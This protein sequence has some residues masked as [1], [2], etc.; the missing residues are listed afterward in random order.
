MYL[1]LYKVSRVSSWISN[2]RRSIRLSSLNPIRAKNASG[3]V[4]IRT[5]LAADP[6]L[7]GLTKADLEVEEVEEDMGADLGFGEERIFDWGEKLSGR[8]M[9]Y[10]ASVGRIRPNG[11]RAPKILKYIIFIIYFV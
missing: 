5:R 8:Q 3:S 1:R 2:S 11:D 6:E 9:G 4:A 7:L 10:L